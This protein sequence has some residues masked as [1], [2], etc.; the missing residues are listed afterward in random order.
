M[1]PQEPIP[2]NYSIRGLN[3]IFLWSSL[4][5]L[6]VT[7]LMV[8]YDYIRGWKWFQ[9]E[10]MR[11]QRERIAQDMHVAETETNKAQL[12]ELD[13]K[14]R[15][16][17]VDI[18]Q[19]RTQYMLAQK[20]LDSW[21]GIHYA[22]DQDYRFAKARLDAQR[23]IAEAS[24]VQKRKD[25]QAQQAEY[26]RQEAHV[27]DLN[28]RLQE[29]SRKR[30]DAKRRVDLWLGKI[31]E[32]EDKRKELTATM[33]LLNK[34]LTTVALSGPNLILNLP[35]LDFINPTLKIDQV[36]IPDMFVE[37]NYMVVPRVDRCQTCHRAIDRPGFESKKEAARLA[38]ELQQKLDA[39]QIVQEKREET[40]KRIA[41]LKRIQ[42][43]PLDVLNPWRTH[44]K[45]DVFVGSVSSHPILEY[46]CTGCHRGQDRATEFGRAGHVPPNKKMEDRWSE[47]FVSLV[48][49]PWDYKKRHWA[50]EE[51]P[52]N[53]TPMYPRQYYEAGCIKCH[54]GQVGVDQGDQISKATLTVEIYGCY[55]CHK[56]NNWRFSDLRKPGPDLNGIAEKTTPDWAF[57]WISEPHNFRSTTRM[58]SFFYQRNMIDPAVVPAP[59]IKQNIKYQ[60]AEIHSIVTYLFGK[61]THRVWAPPPVKGDAA[62]GK[63]MVESVGCMACHIESETIKDPQS[64]QM[65]LARRD[66]YPLERNY[67]FNFTGVGTKTHAGW[68][69]NW[70]KNPKNYYADA[71][72]PSL[73]LTDQ[74]AADVTAYLVTQQKPQFMTTPI[75]P[76]DPAA[77]HDLAMGYLINTLSVREAEAKLRSMPLHEQLNFLGQ[78]SIEKY[79]CY[80]CHNIKGFEGLK[81]I[82]TE[83]TTEG[84][85]ALHLFDFGFAHQYTAEDGKKEHIIHTVP[86]W[87]YN[88][89]RNPR[90]YDDTRTKSY[91]DKLKMPNFHLSQDEADRVTMV[92]LGLTKDIV[93]S[94]K[95]AAMDSRMRQIEEGRK[96][97]SQHNCRGCHVVDGRGRA[98]ADTIADTNF[99]PP[100]LSP[101]GGRAQSPWL[102]NFLKDPTVM[103][104]RPWLNVRMPTFHFTDEEANTL[105][106]FFAEEGKASQFD[107][108]LGVHPPPANVAIGKAVFNMMRC[109]QCHVTTPVNPENPPKPVTVDTTS[110]APNLTLARIRLRHDWIADWIRRP[111]EMI[112]G[113]RMPTNFPRDPAT[114]GFQSPLGMAIDTPAFAQYKSALLPYFKGD[115]KELRRTMGDAVALTDY[116]RDYIWSIGI[117]QMRNAAPGGEAPAMP[118]APSLPAGVP[119]P[120]VGELRH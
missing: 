64:G 89:V 67:G 25:A 93:G 54:S 66:D 14:V 3:L 75:R 28:V 53:E 43:A 103:K 86:S 27:G 46:G 81:P 118:Q 45:L 92:V 76:L 52:F 44:P 108:T 12:T 114:G 97:V 47:A 117:T 35:M 61:S 107:T 15:Q 110:L 106:T 32:L 34:Q 87:I 57:R 17:E 7:G 116:L 20:D 1:K 41:E 55:A 69:Y 42:D 111:N 68:I 71:P 72:M 109:T 83:L 112:N 90:V 39:Y 51:N 50:W 95:V 62:R 24:I 30:D 33:D 26:K 38:Q 16:A 73:R 94:A 48:P 31:K 113:T 79:G 101:E 105:V 23:Y 65:R 60:D 119:A 21:E 100:D 59:E 19:H 22:A 13:R 88:K 37:M 77:V 104:I 11:M 82:G 9:L 49:G 56:I 96:R 58:P 85:K 36:V 63:Q 115:E 78:R 6:A 84:S 40:E 5:L 10:F 18:A 98:I 91:N 70:I 4:G 99:L 2:H 102:F 80:S 8:G 29:M 74:E 120:K